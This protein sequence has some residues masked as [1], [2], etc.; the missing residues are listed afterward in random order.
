M[1]YKLEPVSK[2]Q[3]QAKRDNAVVTYVGVSIERGGTV[4]NSVVRVTDAVVVNQNMI[5]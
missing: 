4:L 1:Q 2:A 5:K 3:T